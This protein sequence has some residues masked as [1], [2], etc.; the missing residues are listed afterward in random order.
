[1]TEADKQIQ[2]ERIEQSANKLEAEWDVTARQIADNTG[3]KAIW[4]FFLGL[5]VGA[6]VG[7]LTVGILA[8]LVP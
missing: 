8:R 1:M 5:I 6:S 4:T 7:A 3:R 2:R